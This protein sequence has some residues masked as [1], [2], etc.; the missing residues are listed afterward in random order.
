MYKLRLMPSLFYLFCIWLLISHVDS[1]LPRPRRRGRNSGRT[2]NGYRRYVGSSGSSNDGSSSGDTTD[3]SSEGEQPAIGMAPREP[4]HEFFH[5]GHAGP[6]HFAEPGDR[7]RWQMLPYNFFVPI[8]IPGYG[9]L[10][11]LEYEPVLGRPGIPTLPSHHPDEAHDPT[12]FHLRIRLQHNS[13]LHMLAANGIGIDSIVITAQMR[14]VLRH[15][16]P[17]AVVN[18]VN[19]VGREDDAPGELTW[20]SDEARERRAALNVH[21]PPVQELYRAYLGSD[22]LSHAQT[23]FMIV[24]TVVLREYAL[25]GRYQMHPGCG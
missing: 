6:F 14:E 17:G 8:N 11:Q 3:C 7:G 15:D 25:G 4:R 24:F 16:R 19:S 2:R 12:R 10:G 5:R 18:P 23:S 9:H 22:L 13:I 1:V 21:L 20:L